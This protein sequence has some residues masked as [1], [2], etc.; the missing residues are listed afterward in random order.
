MLPSQRRWELKIERDLCK[1]KHRKLIGCGS[2]ER[3]LFRRFIF[4][5][6]NFEKIKLV[7]RKLRDELS[8]WAFSLSMCWNILYPN[9]PSQDTWLVNFEFFTSVK[10]PHWITKVSLLITCR[11]VVLTSYQAH[12]VCHL[13]LPLI[14][15]VTCKIHIPLFLLAIVFES[16]SV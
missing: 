4:L 10:A 16:T 6:T 1:I 12:I 13:K 8:L 3:K 11:R 9:Y 15:S 7:V 5:S 14:Q 2:F